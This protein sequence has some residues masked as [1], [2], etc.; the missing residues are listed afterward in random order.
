MDHL[1]G[2][3]FEQD[4]MSVEQLVHAPTEQGPLRDFRA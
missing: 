3:Q 1:M 4:L 2:G